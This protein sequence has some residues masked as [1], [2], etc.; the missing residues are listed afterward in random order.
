MTFTKLQAP[1][2]RPTR[3]PPL[4]AGKLNFKPTPLP[5][6]SRHSHPTS[7]HISPSSANF[8]QFKMSKH[9]AEA[10]DVIIN[11]H[12]AA[13]HHLSID[14]ASRMA[15]QQYIDSL[16]QETLKRLMARVYYQK[17]NRRLRREMAELLVELMVAGG[18][19]VDLSH[20]SLTTLE[21]VELTK[22]R[23]GHQ[24]EKRAKIATYNRNDLYDVYDDWSYEDGNRAHIECAA[25]T[26]MDSWVNQNKGGANS[27]A[28]EIVFPVLVQE[29]AED[30]EE[31]QDTPIGLS[32][33]G[34][35]P[36][37]PPGT[38]DDEEMP[39]ADGNEEQGDDVVQSGEEDDL[40]PRSLRPRKPKAPSPPPKPPPQK[41]PKKSKGLQPVSM[42]ISIFLPSDASIG[43]D[44][45][46]IGILPPA[47]RTTLVNRFYDRI[48]DNEVRTETYER[49]TRN[50]EGYMKGSCILKYLFAKKQ[51]RQIVH[52][53]QMACRTCANEKRVCVDFVKLDDFR[54]CIYPRAEGERGD[55]TWDQ[56]GFWA[57][58]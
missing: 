57:E 17:L 42:A 5:I 30:M 56:L 18:D 25:A 11:L 12:L 22:T 28:S 50:P 41:K 24:D 52:G 7:L 34:P 29:L 53:K 15:R 35:F 39:L 13:L 23:P 36:E 46:D 58:P 55:A 6:Y 43:G 40:F 3:F 19:Q 54:L 14:P 49:M 51:G 48:K 9:L 37:H 31:V 45:R 20:A 44:F 1:P 4:S 47:I 38:I 21:L 32:V 33:F 27:N 8:I 2:S 16:S 10:I 26:M